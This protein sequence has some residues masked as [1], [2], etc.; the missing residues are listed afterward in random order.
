MQLRSFR[1]NLQHGSTKPEAAW[2]ACN[3]NFKLCFPYFIEF[4]N[5]LKCNHKA[6]GQAS[7]MSLSCLERMLFYPS[8][9]LIHGSQ[10]ALKCNREANDL[11]KVQMRT[12]GPWY[13]LKSWLKPSW[14]SCGSID[15]FSQNCT[16]SAGSAAMTVY[17]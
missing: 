11:L 2:K 5:T 6:S 14:F 3:M 8:I 4:R 7:A 17:Q 15:P 16:T 12:T 13:E 1:S 10:N 9:F